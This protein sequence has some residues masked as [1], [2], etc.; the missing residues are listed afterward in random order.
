MTL[1]ELKDAFTRTMQVYI[2]ALDRYTDEQFAAKPDEQEWSLGQMYEHLYGA[3]TY[4]FLA[5]VKRCLEQRKGQEG[6]EMNANGQN[7]FKYNSFPPI[8]VKVP[9]AVRGPEP[10]AKSRE[11]YKVLFKG[12][13][14]DGLALADAA[15]ADAGIYKTQ[16][17]VFGWMNVLEWFQGMETHARHHFRQ[18]K[19]REDWL[20]ITVV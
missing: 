19:E 16:H 7:V 9:E 14:R 2:T 10:V 15:A 18:Q 3:N 5:N 6:G 20:G 13:L 1:D 8:K 17:P 4:F 12:T 11:T